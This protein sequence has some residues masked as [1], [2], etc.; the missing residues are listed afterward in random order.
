[1]NAASAKADFGYIDKWGE[2][3]SHDADGEFNRPYGIAIDSDGN[4]FVADTANYRVQKFDWRGDHLNAW[5]SIWDDPL[6]APLSIAV[7]GNG[8]FIVTEHYR[9]SVDDWATF[10]FRVR[11]IDS[12]G[13]V[14]A[15]WGQKG[16]GNGKF[17]LPYGI[18]VDSD[19]NVYVADTNNNRIQKFSPDGDF[20]GKWGRLCNVEE[21]GVDACDGKFDHPAGVTVDEAGDVYVADSYNH[22]IQK[23]DSNGG[24]L[25]KWGSNCVVEDSQIQHPDACDGKFNIPIDISVDQDG[26][27]Y[28]ADTFNSRVQKFILNQGQ[29]EYDS[30]WGVK[31]IV[32]YRGDPDTCEGD[33]NYPYGVEI[34]RNGQ[35]YVADSHNYRIQRFGQRPESTVPSPPS[36]SSSPAE[37]LALPNLEL[38]RSHGRKDGVSVRLPGANGGSRIGCPQA[39]V[40][41]DLRNGCTTSIHQRTNVE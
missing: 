18:A 23:F 2:Y 12:N 34:G 21:Q 15:Q 41:D 20:L 7:D 17:N 8:N 4:I 39:G 24:F 31:C 9:S 28:V 26:T 6:A 1:M 19:D 33:F 40:R 37:A 30:K 35:I 14:L 10:N 29:Y 3:G 22:R 5:G 32:D 16:R 36:R 25:G 27:A 13:V 11:K 38:P